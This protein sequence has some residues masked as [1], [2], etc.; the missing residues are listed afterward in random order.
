VSVLTV[1]FMVMIRTIRVHSLL[2][3]VAV[4]WIMGGGGG[5]FLQ[6]TK[7]WSNMGRI[8]MHYGRMTQAIVVVRAMAETTTTTKG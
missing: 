5:L 7:A 3:V 2:M 1:F 4:T 8:L 6:V